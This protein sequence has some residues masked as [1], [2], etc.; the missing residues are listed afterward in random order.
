MKGGAK[1]RK[2]YN[3]VSNEVKAKNITKSIKFCYTLRNLL[4]YFSKK[5]K[6]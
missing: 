4:L 5:Y 6:I 1:Y 2:V 3:V